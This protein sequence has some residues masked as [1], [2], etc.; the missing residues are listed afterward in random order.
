MPNLI[1]SLKPLRLDNY[2]PSNIF[3]P[4]VT[5]S[6][7]Y[8]RSIRQ[9]DFYGSGVAAVNRAVKSGGEERIFIRLQDRE[10][11]GRGHGLNG[12]WDRVTSYVA[13]A[14]APWIPERRERRRVSTLHEDGNSY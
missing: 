3:F 1:Q 6:V 14:S 5:S 8:Y 13:L 2:H 7:E 11:G 10:S 4:Q 12:S 9:I